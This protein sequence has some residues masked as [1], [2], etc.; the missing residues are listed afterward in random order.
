MWEKAVMSAVC[1]KVKNLELMKME[2]T[3]MRYHPRGK[4]SVQ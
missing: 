2:E 3:V 1:S 4:K